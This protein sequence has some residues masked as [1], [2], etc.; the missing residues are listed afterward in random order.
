MKK[1]LYLCVVLMGCET[2]NVEVSNTQYQISGRQI[3]LYVIDSCEYLGQV[4]N[5][6]TDI[7]THKGNC[8]YCTERLKLL[9]G[10]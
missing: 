1:L 8:K 9:Y 10:K 4:N 3:N 5:M 7:I 2:A 6:Q